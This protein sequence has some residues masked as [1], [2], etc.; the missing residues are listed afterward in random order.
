MKQKTIYT[1]PGPE[2]KEEME[3]M[4]RI[5]DFLPSPEFLMSLRKG[6]RTGEPIGK[7]GL[8][9]PSGFPVR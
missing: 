6:T 7:F 5:D 3:N 8:A 1:D 9:E 4:V 2:I